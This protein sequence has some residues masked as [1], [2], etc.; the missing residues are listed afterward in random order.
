MDAT[1]AGAEAEADVGPSIF[2]YLFMSEFPYVPSYGIAGS[3]K[4][5]GFNPLIYEFYTVFSASYAASGFGWFA[6][7]GNMTEYM[8]Q[9]GPLGGL[10]WTWYNAV[11]IPEKVAMR[12]ANFLTAY[13]EAVYTDAY[14]R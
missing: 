11:V 1:A 4:N 10:I 7:L 6:A 9:L 8:D 5:Q 13:C 14:I 3:Y 2:D 12:N